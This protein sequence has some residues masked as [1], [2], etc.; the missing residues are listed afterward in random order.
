MYAKVSDLAAKYRFSVDAIYAWVRSGLI[1][2]SCVLRVGASIRIDVEQFEQLL[3]AGKLYR[4]RRTW[5]EVRARHSRDAAA[6]LGLSD[7]QHT[8]CYDRGECQHRFLDDQAAVVAYH[9]YSVEM[10]ALTR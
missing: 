5:A 1:P 6:A 7:D 2:K 9:P 3:L 4:A 8:T 10:K